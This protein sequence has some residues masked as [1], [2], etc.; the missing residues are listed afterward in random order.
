MNLNLE[1]VL[2]N[3]SSPVLVAKPIKNEFSNIIDFEINY[4]NEE[5]KKAVGFVIGNSTKWSDFEGKIT[6]DV[7]WF[8]LAL[9]AIEG[10]TYDSAKYYSPSTKCWYK[11]DMK[12]NEALGVII[13]TFINITSEQDYYIQLQKSLSTDVLTKLPNRT[14]FNESLRID[15][16]D[17]NFNKKYAAL[18]LIDIDNLKNIND[19]QGINFGDKL[20]LKTTSILKLFQ[21]DKVKIF[22]YG[23]DEFA[24]ILKNFDSEASIVNFTDCI[25]EAFQMQQLKVSGGIAL[26]KVH[27]SQ[28]EE[29]IRFAD[30]AVHYAK[31]NGRN[32]FTFFEPEMHRIFIQHL[33][34]QSKMSKAIIESKFQQY[35]QPQFDI[36]SGQLRGFEALIRWNDEEL[37]NIAPSV[38]IPLAEETGSIVE[39]GNWVL[40]TALKTLKHW[41]EKFDF[42]GV[43]SVNVSP[44]QL[45]QDDFLYNL[46]RLIN[47]NEIT[48]SLLEIE[49]TEG[50][51]INDINAT[52]EKLN[53]IRNMGIRLSLDDFGTGYSSL[54]YLQQLPLNTLKID[55]SFINNI[56]SEDGIQ[57][58]I[59]QSII[60]MVEKMG[61]ETIAEGVEYQDQL[62]LLDKFNCNIVQGFLRGKPMPFHLCEAYLDGDTSAL[63]KN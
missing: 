52:I 58:N 7:P 39:I 25:F 49:I 30:M 35:Y 18:L 23:D 33:T 61:L 9:D 44:I 14:T 55:K 50:V 28:V 1:L 34:I 51:M 31:K 11:I 41:Q 53:A 40:E 29:L 43:I 54:S 22:R 60:S 21:S 13:L 6:S 62:A 45:M 2:N 36:H 38:F 10:N 26:S 3:I 27:T 42:H 63:L 48:S 16:E 4:T 5:M 59:T 37:G 17:S 19:S 32:N 56:T 15:M 24:M 57:A 12:F 20:I 46:E 47:E 8:P